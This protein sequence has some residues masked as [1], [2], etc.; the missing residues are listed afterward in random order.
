MLYNLYNL[1]YLYYQGFCVAFLA[2]IILRVVALRLLLAGM[3]SSLSVLPSTSVLLLLAMYLFAGP[4][5]FFF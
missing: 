1:Y 5:L 4:R 2:E 3:W